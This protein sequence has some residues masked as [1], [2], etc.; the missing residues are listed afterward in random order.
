M[1]KTYAKGSKFE[2][3]LLNYLHFKGFSVCR[4]ASSGGWYT[5]T[6][7][8]AI[9]NGTVLAIECK[10]WAK[11]PRLEKEKIRRF[12]EWCEKA[13]AHGFLAWKQTG[14]IWKFLTLKDAE[15]GNYQDERWFS[16]DDINR[17]FML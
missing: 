16:L 12:K 3:D 14:N 15:D 2:R 11:K 8:I 7:V 13:G 9:R 17:V 6:D 5:P 4:I 10:A 1:V